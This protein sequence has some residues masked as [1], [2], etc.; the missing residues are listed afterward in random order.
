MAPRNDSSP[1]P[2]KG[3]GQHLFTP[4]RSRN[5]DRMWLRDTRRSNAG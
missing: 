2:Y 1:S 5:A 3:I 4:Y